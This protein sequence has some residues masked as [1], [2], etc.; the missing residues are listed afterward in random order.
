MS[1]KK[2]FTRFAV[3]LAV[4][5]TPVFAAEDFFNDLPE[6][7]AP[8]AIETKS[9]LT[10]F[11]KKEMTEEK[12]VAQL[13]Q[14]I[15]KQKRFFKK[16]LSGVVDSSKEVA[17]FK[18]DLAL[19]E[20]NV[21]KVLAEVDAYIAK[22]ETSKPTDPNAELSEFDKALEE[23]E[24]LR[25]RIQTLVSEMKLRRDKT[26]HKHKLMFEIPINKDLK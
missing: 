1:V 20:F 5:M 16:Y 14:L 21:V 18:V 11:F 6:V 25:T 26:W 24:S 7:T 12:M 17:E 22:N 9:K 15:R 23:E 10:G 4:I 19:L 13:K 2:Y 8:P 3:T